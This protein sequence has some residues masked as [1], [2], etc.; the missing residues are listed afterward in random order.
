MHFD[1]DH[2][3]RLH[4]DAP[5]DHRGGIFLLDEFSIISRA[6]AVIAD[7]CENSTTPSFHLVLMANALQG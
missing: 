2:S 4:G 3:L 6:P 1:H 7:R 5:K